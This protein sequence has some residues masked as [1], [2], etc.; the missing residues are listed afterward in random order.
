MEVPGKL[1]T[2]EVVIERVALRQ[3]PGDTILVKDT[4]KMCADGAG[5]D[6]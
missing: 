5:T 2:Q 1:L 6:D 3:I 4:G